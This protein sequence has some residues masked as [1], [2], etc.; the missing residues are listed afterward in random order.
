[1]S[2]FYSG[3]FKKMNRNVKAMSSTTRKDSDKNCKIEIMVEDVLKEIREIKKDM[4]KYNFHMRM[5]TVD[6]NNYFP[7]K[8]DEDID[9]FLEQ[10]EEWNLRK[11]VFNFFH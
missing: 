8:S 1:M 3:L 11:K 6:L 2:I 10:D 5:D 9:R 4:M 7:V